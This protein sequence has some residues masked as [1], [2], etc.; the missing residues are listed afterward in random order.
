MYVERE[1]IGQTIGTALNDFIHDFQHSMFTI[2]S[3]KLFSEKRNNKVRAL[4]HNDR[5]TNKKLH[6][7]RLIN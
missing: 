6:S 2:F 1:I 3:K 5:D 4:V 7:D